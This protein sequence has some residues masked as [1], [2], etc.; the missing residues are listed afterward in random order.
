MSSYYSEKYTLTFEKYYGEGMGKKAEEEFNKLG[1]CSYHFASK[2]RMGYDVKFPNVGYKCQLCGN[3]EIVL[4][5]NK[6]YCRYCIMFDKSSS[7]SRT[8]DGFRSS[9]NYKDI[10]YAK[11]LKTMTFL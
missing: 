8:L 1:Y 7:A 10:K 2:L 11:Y 3:D 6:A 4:C 5:N 9:R